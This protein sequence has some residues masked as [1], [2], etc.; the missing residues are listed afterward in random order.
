MSTMLIDTFVEK[1]GNHIPLVRRNH[2]GGYI[3]R[4]PLSQVRLLGIEAVR[5]QGLQTEEDAGRFYPYSPPPSPRIIRGTPSSSASPPRSAPAS[6]WDLP[7]RSPR[8]ANCLAA[9][10]R[11][12][13]V[14][15]A[16]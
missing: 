7:K 4:K 6:R 14:W 3:Q 2:I 12:C 11:V 5:R 1:F 15:A 10:R 8:T 13:A 9:G 16:G